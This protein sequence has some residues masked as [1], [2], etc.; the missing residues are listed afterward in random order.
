MDGINAV[1][2]LA[3]ETFIVDILM[4]PGDPEI[5]QYVNDLKLYVSIKNIVLE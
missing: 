5:L 4:A 1:V 3:K 2:S